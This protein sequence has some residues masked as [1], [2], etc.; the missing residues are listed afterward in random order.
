MARSGTVRAVER[1]SEQLVDHKTAMQPRDG[2]KIGCPELWVLCDLCCGD[3]FQP[4]F[5][6]IE[7]RSEHQVDKNGSEPLERASFS[8]CLADRGPSQKGILPARTHGHS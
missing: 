2:P 8:K 3:P 6:I 7:L 4:D 1:R 5:G